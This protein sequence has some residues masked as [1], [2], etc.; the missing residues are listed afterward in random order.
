MVFRRDLLRSTA[1]ASLVGVMG[2][3]GVSSFPSS[4]KAE[5]NRAGEQG[6]A[7]DQTTVRQLAKTLAQQP[8]KAPNDRLPEAID[9]L[10]FDGFR[11]IAFRPEKALWNAD[12]LNFAVQ[13]FPRGFL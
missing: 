9:K 6:K 3:A 8:Y 7:F 2:I 12:N 11:G 5:E 1:G 4:A 13:F 10:D